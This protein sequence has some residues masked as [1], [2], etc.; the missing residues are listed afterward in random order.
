MTSLKYV[1]LEFGEIFVRGGIAGE[2]CPRFILKHNLNEIRDDSLY[3]YISELFQKMFVGQLQMKPKL[4]NV[5]VVEKFLARRK[6]RDQILSSLLQEFKVNSVSMQPDLYMAVVA[7]GCRSGIVINIGETECE[8]LCIAEGRPLINSFQVAS[9]GVKDSIRSLKDTVEKQLNKA[10][11]MHAIEPVFERI[12]C[13]VAEGQS[14]KISDVI[15]LPSDGVSATPFTIAAE[16]RQYCLELLITGENTTEG[17]VDEMGGVVGI[18]LRSL[19]AVAVDIRSQVAQ[20]IVFIGGGAMISGLVREI[21]ARAT[22]IA[23]SDPYFKRSVGAVL[24]NLPLQRF[25]AAPAAF[26]RSTAAWVGGSLFASL[27]SSAAKFLTLKDFKGRL[28][29]LDLLSTPCAPMPTGVVR[30][31]SDNSDNKD[32]VEITNVAELEQEKAIDTSTIALGENAS[33]NSTVATLIATEAQ[34][35][36]ERSALL[37]PPVISA[38]DWQSLDSS[39]WVFYRTTR[40]LTDVTAMPIKSST[41]STQ[42]SSRKSP[43]LSSTTSTKTVRAPPTRSSTAPT[44]ASRS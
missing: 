11:S 25:S 4:C 2:H 22:E 16:A 14:S 34:A 10:V 19:R 12:A 24:K 35:N 40:S 6:L 41:T 30:G 32:G 39:D 18:L 9:V 17:C 15:V 33:C 29:K 26:P 23:S 8:A 27:K 20:R 21:C 13:C 38:P 1:V 7:S 43:V 36:M 28:Q 37:K 44:G 42:S 5:L 31:V 3:L